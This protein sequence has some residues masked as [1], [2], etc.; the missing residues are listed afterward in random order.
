M[1][2]SLFLLKPDA[3]LRR[4]S[5]VDVLK[6]LRDLEN[7]SVV[8][9]KEVKVS[10]SLAKKHYAEHEGKSFFPWLIDMITAP[11]GVS[12]VILEGDGVVQK[13]RDLL[14]PT[15]VEDA[16]KVK[17][18]LRGKYGI[19]KGVN[20][21][22]ASDSPESGEKE[23]NLWINELGLDTGSRGNQLA[24]EDYIKKWDGKYPD[25]TKKVQK[26][27]KQLPKSID[28]LKNTL[29]SETNEEESD[30][31]YLVKIISETTN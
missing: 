6:E 11:S 16:I 10:E 9:F 28:K 17:G 19:I 5:G 15:F 14:G 3:V 12:V 29:Q 21:A 25:K 24:M 27:S 8:S 30:V 20:V 2:R 7:V 23:T 4:Q 22:H 26:L 13:V 18:A 31:E 1:E